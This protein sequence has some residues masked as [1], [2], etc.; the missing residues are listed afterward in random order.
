M[1]LRRETTRLLMLVLA[2]CAFA[3]VRPAA[4][5]P[6]PDLLGGT[7]LEDPYSPWSATRISEARWYVAADALM[8]MRDSTPSRPFASVSAPDFIVLGTHDLE[9][10]LQAGPQVTLG[11]RLGKV[12]Q[13]EV[14][15][16][17]LTSWSD[18]AAVRDLSD[19]DLGGQGNLFSPFG[20]FGIA[21]IVGLD[22]NDLA[23]IEYRSELNNLEFNLR[24]QLPLPPGPLGVTVLVGGRWMNILERFGYYTESHTP[25]GTAYSND[26]HVQTGNNLLGIQIGALLELQVE[27]R[28]QITLDLKGG[29]FNDAADQATAYTFVGPQGAQT[30][31]GSRTDNVTAW[32]GE[33][34]L[35]FTYQITP[36]LTCRAG[37]QMLWVEGI[38]QASD[39][40]EAN[41]GLL[42]AGPTDLRHDGHAVYHGPHIGLVLRL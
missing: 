32:V 33:I 21:P 25:V 12:Y 18:R 24:Q 26:V 5:Q 13:F 42:V 14:S 23:V 28:S 17:D 20:N 15:W 6:Q 7:A 27:Y 34:T 9:A 19:N 11:H 41:Y 1:G 8:L 39:N 4:A 36:R 37:Y 3:P 30:F 22:Y 31:T 40:F 2:A 29:I 16:F 38:A 10:G 35:D